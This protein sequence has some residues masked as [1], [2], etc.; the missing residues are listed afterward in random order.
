MHLQ[1]KYTYEWLSL[2]FFFWGGW[3]VHNNTANQNKNKRLKS[4]PPILQH[5]NPPQCLFLCCN[6]S[7]TSLIDQLI[8]QRCPTK[9]FRRLSWNT[10]EP[11]PPSK[12]T[13]EWFMSLFLMEIQKTF[14]MQPDHWASDETNEFKTLHF[15]LARTFNNA[16]RSL[17]QIGFQ[18][19]H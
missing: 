11:P 8:L 1:N 7:F 9:L 18:C 13:P 10:N 2:A 19:C 14:S 12:Q 17:G 5:L 15:K 16:V 3:L 4:N 6:L